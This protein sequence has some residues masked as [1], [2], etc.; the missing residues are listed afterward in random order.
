[1]TTHEDGPRVGIFGIEAKLAAMQQQPN[2]ELTNLVG[3]TR[4]LLDEFGVDA[5]VIS[6]AELPADTNDDKYREPATTT[7]SYVEQRIAGKTY[8][9]RPVR[10]GNDGDIFLALDETQPEG[11]VTVRD[12]NLITLGGGNKDNQPTLDVMGAINNPVDVKTADVIIKQI[13]GQESDRKAEQDRR[14]LTEELRRQDQERFRQQEQERQ[15]ALER[16]RAQLD[17]VPFYVRGINKITRN[18]DDIISGA[19]TAVIAGIAIAGLVKL[20][21]GIKSGICGDDCKVEQYDKQKNRITEGVIVRQGTTQT[22]PHTFEATQSTKLGESE[23]PELGSYDDGT[24]DDGQYSIGFG[25]NVNDLSDDDSAPIS[26]PRQIVLVPPDEEKVKTPF[27]ESNKV[28]FKTPYDAVIA[29]TDSSEKFARLMQI[30]LTDS[31]L[32][33]CWTGSAQDLQKA[34][35]PRVI[36]QRATPLQ[37]ASLGQK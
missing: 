20:A 28:S 24:T 23:V 3:N 19:I 17:S 6:G 29:A 18:S 9:I 22:T 2:L 4:E 26:N 13:A 15:A 14:D 37:I 30:S 27:C 33:V 10:F 36:F 21:P 1:M 5:E 25:P 11:K 35:Y 16:E 31:V 12:I 8:Y 7:R 34:K 32:R